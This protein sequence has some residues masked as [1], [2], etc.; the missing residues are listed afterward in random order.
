MS[1]PL[2]LPRR[3]RPFGARIAAA[4]AAVVLVGFTAF[5]WLALPRSARAT[6]GLAERLTVVVIYAGL[7]AVLAT[8]TFGVVDPSRALALSQVPTLRWF[9]VAVWVLAGVRVT[10]VAVRRG[11]AASVRVGLGLTLLAVAHC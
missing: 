8:I 1:E 2:R 4:V 9:V 7:L 3:Y 11:L 10:R 5:I 6:F